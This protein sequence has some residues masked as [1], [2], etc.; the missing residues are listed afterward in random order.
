MNN[1]PMYRVYARP[2]TEDGRVPTKKLESGKEV[3]IEWATMWPGKEGKGPTLTLN[4]DHPAIQ[5]KWETGPD[6]KRRC[7]HFLNCQA[8]RDPK[9]DN[10]W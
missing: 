9:A 6:G 8:P 2:A 4:P 7:S 10:G 3:W 5:I 1:K